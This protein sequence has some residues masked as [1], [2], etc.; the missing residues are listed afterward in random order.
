M[1][2]VTQAVLTFAG[3]L[4]P[5]LLIAAAITIHGRQGAQAALQHLQTDPYWNNLPTS[6]KT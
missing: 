2:P 1:S 3:A 6:N 4:T 5:G